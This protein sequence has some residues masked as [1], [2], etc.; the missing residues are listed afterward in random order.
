MRSI[1]AFAALCIFAAALPISAAEAPLL[2]GADKI[3]P[4]PGVSPLANGT[5]LI[6]SGRIASVADERAR[7]A[8]PA[9][10]QTSDC[11][12]VVVAGFQNSH[13][14]FIE[15]RFRDAATR[16]ASQLSGDLE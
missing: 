2:L 13:V 8:I 7:M 6:R 4:A 15:P 10:A 12:G 1:A 3:Y 5:I 16:P 11:R 9:G 14:H